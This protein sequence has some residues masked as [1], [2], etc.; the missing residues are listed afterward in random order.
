VD[1]ETG[2]DDLSVA[3]FDDTNDSTKFS[4]RS[5][6]S[7]Q[8]RSSVED[9][10]LPRRALSVGSADREW[11]SGGK[12]RQ[13]IN[14]ASEDVTIVI[15][16]FTTNTLGALLYYLLCSLTL[17]FAFLLFRWF[18]RWRIRLIGRVSPLKTCDWIVVEVG[19]VNSIPT[20]CSM[21]TCSGSM[22]TTQHL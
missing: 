20:E 2:V 7:F 15:T 9:P 22:E 6:P 14:I 11:K 1:L 18:P 10:L 13:E 19:A 3:D 8:Q 5:R 4:F 17:G 12:V 21:L 16:G